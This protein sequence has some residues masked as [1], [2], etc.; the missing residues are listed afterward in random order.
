MKLGRV[1]FMKAT[2]YLTPGKDIGKNELKAC[3]QMISDQLLDRHVYLYSKI[4]M[5]TQYEKLIRADMYIVLLAIVVT[6][7]VF[8][9]VY[10]ESLLVGLILFLTYLMALGIT[11]LVYIGILGNTEVSQVNLIALFIQIGTGTTHM[12]LLADASK[13]SEAIKVFKSSTKTKMSFIWN[14]CSIMTT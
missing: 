11:Y 7:V 5:D 13:Q 14:R 1:S 8:V 2:I 4:L 12:F 6:F 3:H 9:S 10:V